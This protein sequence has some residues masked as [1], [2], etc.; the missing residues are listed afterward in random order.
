MLSVT[1]GQLLCVGLTAAESALTAR[2]VLGLQDGSCL[3]NSSN[4]SMRIKHGV[5][6]VGY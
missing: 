2:D 5:N 1:V 3:E 4:T 6:S